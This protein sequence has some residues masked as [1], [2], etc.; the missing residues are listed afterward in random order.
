MLLATTMLAVLPLMR[1]FSESCDGSGARFGC[2]FFSLFNLYHVGIRSKKSSSIILFELYIHI[3]SSKYSQ[4]FKI[5]DNVENVFFYITISTVVMG[6]YHKQI[7]I[8]KVGLKN[9]FCSSKLPSV[10]MVN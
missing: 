3:Y 9:C 2:Y 1:D 6:D 7:N 4:V 5:I 8:N 10:S